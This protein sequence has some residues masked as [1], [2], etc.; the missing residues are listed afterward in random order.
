M[1][2][3]LMFSEYHPP[4]KLP[5][6]DIPGGS[7]DAFPQPNSPFPRFLLLSINQNLHP[8]HKKGKCFSGSDNG[9]DRRRQPDGCIFLLQFL[10]LFRLRL[11]TVDSFLSA[12]P[13]Y[14]EPGL[15]LSSRPC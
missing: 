8:K 13:P 3:V 2:H 1:R 6:C 12:G 10:H 15:I 14:P 7:T 4:R 11:G 5:P 9:H